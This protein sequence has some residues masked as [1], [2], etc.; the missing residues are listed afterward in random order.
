MDWGTVIVMILAILGAALIVGGV[1]AYRGSP[2]TGVRTFAAASIAAGIVM[3]AIVLLTTPVFV[4]REGGTSEP[5]VHI[6]P[7]VNTSI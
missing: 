1:V 7:V 6:D 5:A 2:K 3:W 4:T